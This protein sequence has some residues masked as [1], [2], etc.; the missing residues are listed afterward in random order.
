MRLNIFI[1]RPILAT[2]I[3]L[4]IVLCGVV[5]VFNLPVS[6]FP[7][8]SPPSISIN[9]AYPGANAETAAKVVAAQIENLQGLFSSHLLRIALPIYLLPCELLKS[10]TLGLQLPLSNRHSTANN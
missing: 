6:Q 5:A 7:D 10:S 1:R 9:A 3:S 8:V 4:I 2:V